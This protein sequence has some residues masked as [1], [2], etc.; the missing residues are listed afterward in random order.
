VAGKAQNLTMS[1]SDQT[2]VLEGPAVYRIIAATQPAFI[3][4]ADATV[5]G[6][7]EYLAANAERFLQVPAAGLTLHVVQG[8][9]AGVLYASQCTDVW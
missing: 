5:A 7:R 1:A 4:Q 2:L 9:T 6:N 3:G 8:G